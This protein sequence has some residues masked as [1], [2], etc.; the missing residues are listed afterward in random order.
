M[1]PYINAGAAYQY[2]ITGNYLHI[3]ETENHLYNDVSTDLDNDFTFKPG[4][5]SGLIGF[6]T[7]TRILN[8]LNLHIEARIEYGS[9]FFVN[10]NPNIDN[11][12][13]TKKPYIQNSLQYGIQLGVSF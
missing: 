6:G 12:N 4:E 13:I 11:T 8:N 2:F 7:R 10:Y 3:K 5:L 1:T 9:G